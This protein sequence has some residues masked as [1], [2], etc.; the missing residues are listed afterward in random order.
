MKFQIKNLRTSR[1]LRSLFILW[2]LTAISC[3]IIFSPFLFGENLAVFNDAG[4]DTRQQYLMQYATIVN[5]IR[6]GNLSLWDLNNGFGTS[7]FALNL[8]NPFLMLVYLAGIL[9]G[10]GHIPGVLVFLIILEIFLAGTFCYFFLDCFSFSEGSKITASYI[11]GLNGYLLVWGQHYQFGAFAVFLPLLLFLLERAI[12]QKK[13]SL[14]APLLIA[15]MVCSS[16]YMSYMSLILAGCYLI[17]RL[18]IQEADSRKTRAGQ[19]FIHCASMLLGI[20]I[21]MVIFLPM[22]YYLLTISSRLDSDASLLQR[23]LEYC[24]PYSLKF[25]KTA[26]LRFFS[27]T[28]QGIGDYNGYSNFYEAPVLFFSSLFV[29]LA[30][31]YVFTIHTQKVSR[32]KKVMQYLSILFFFFC[33]FSR[34]GASVFNAFAYPFSRHSFL[35]MPLFA[36]MMAFILDQLWLRRKINYPAF[37][38]SCFFLAAGHFTAFGEITEPELR[39]NVILMGILG[40]FTAG[41]LIAGFLKHGKHPRKLTVTLLLVT[42]ASGMCLEGYTC[43]NDRDTL[44]TTDASYWGGLYNPNVAAALDYLE[45]TDTSLYRVEKDYYSGSFC[46]DALAQNYRGISTYNST[47]NRNVEE[48]IKLVTPNMPIMAE[49]EYTYRQIGYYTGHSS[50]FGIKYLLSQNPKL[51]LNGFTLLKQFDNIYIYQNSN[52]TSFARFYTSAGD[53]AV[54]KN[55]YGKL[56]LEKMLLENV[57]LDCDE[58]ET[59]A[60]LIKEMTFEELKSQETLSEA[61]ALE[62][63][64]ASVSDFKAETGDSLSIPL[65]RSILDAYERVYMEFDI[66]TPEVSDITVNPEN[67]LEYHFR[68]PKK[69][70]KHVQIAVPASWSEVILSRYGGNFKGTV[71][72]IKFYGSK[73]PVTPYEG[74][75][76]TLCSP[77][78]DSFLTGS[79]DAEN[80]GFLF[81]PIPYENGW[82]AEVD[83]IRTEILR[84]DAGFVSVPVNAGTHT[85]TFAYKVPYMLEGMYASIFSLVIWLLILVFRVFPKPQ[86]HKEK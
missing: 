7:M 83:G 51:Q 29:L 13:F 52:V 39:T 12:R 35:F 20:G 46:M 47:P 66:R 5:H 62:E 63:I 25:Y 1:K 38:L 45:N 65:D 55:A 3:L 44:T 60:S 18:V 4:S 23:F 6:S 54:L 75:V 76:V 34:A 85:F 37:V 14:T 74:A 9:L 33:M 64:P 82:S 86:K 79:I 49:H 61:Y 57:L 19:F 16:V 2:G 8:F 58:E 28:F 84:T 11:Y 22:A 36:L 24:S 67:P 72:N 81:L 17:Y 32:K 68:V 15:V 73:S 48:F 43:Y 70:K 40:L 27:T 77:E 41:I 50:L 59:A 71:K 42:V 56:D 21:G 78:N 53:S 10:P 80:S 30:F 31:Q 69:K 26:F